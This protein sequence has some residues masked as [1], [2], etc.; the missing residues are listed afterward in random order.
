MAD[1]WLG[2]GPLADIQPSTPDD[3]VNQFDFSL[4]ASQWASSGIV[5]SLSPGLNLVSIPVRGNTT[6]LPDLLAS[7]DDKYRSMFL[8]DLQNAGSPWESFVSNRPIYLDALPRIDTN[9]GFWVD[10]TEAAD[11]T[12]SGS[13]LEGTEFTIETGWNLISYPSTMDQAIGTAILGVADVIE[14]VHEYDAANSGS[15]WTSYETTS[16]GSATLASMRP[17]FG[18]W[19]KAIA[20]DLWSW[21]QD[22]YTRK[23]AHLLATHVLVSP[24]VP[25]LLPGQTQKN[26]TLTIGI[27]NT[28]KIV[29][30]Q[31]R[32][33]VF[34][35]TGGGSVLLRDTTLPSIDPESFE[36]FTVVNTFNGGNHPLRIIVDP[37]DTVAEDDETNN[38]FVYNLAIL[39]AATAMAAMNPISGE[40]PIK[41]DFSG[42]ASDGVPPYVHA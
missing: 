24:I 26:V 29:T 28:E 37:F 33:Q 34:D 2:A 40:V 25:M 23:H 42:T 13:S 32:V 4:L 7:I 6:S 30:S 35:E 15:E 31:V 20:D 36:E 39:N 41:I 1:R 14:S 10:M 22:K 18:Y 12:I 21:Q 16:P 9:Q 11:L 38:E 19:V 17:R 3:W 27:S 5:S 8:Y